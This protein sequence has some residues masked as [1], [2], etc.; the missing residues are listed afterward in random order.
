MTSAEQVAGCLVPGF[1]SDP[2]QVDVL[3]GVQQRRSEGDKP[4]FVLRKPGGRAPAV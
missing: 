3:Y 2:S 1:A 4:V